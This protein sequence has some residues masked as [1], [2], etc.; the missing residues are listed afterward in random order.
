MS[1]TSSSPAK[2][3]NRWLL[4]GPLALAALLFIGYSVFWH[5]GA[6]VMRDEVNNW[7]EGERE[8]GMTV[9]HDQIKVSGYPFFLRTVI[10]KP[11]YGN[12]QDD[13]TWQG[14]KLLV[15]V[16]PFNPTRLILSPFGKQNIEF[17][18]GSG[19]VLW[20]V[21]AERMN[22]SLAEDQYAIEIHELQASTAEATRAAP[23]SSIGGKKL[24]L[25]IYIADNP[26]ADIPG[27]LGSLGL[28]IQG[29]ALTTADADTPVSIDY[30][31]AALSAT[32]L[33]A[34]ENKRAGES[35]ID[36]WRRGNGVLDIEA[37]QLIL[38][39]GDLPAPTQI[40]ANGRLTVDREDYPAGKIDATIKD[41]QALLS[42]LQERGAI[43]PSDAEN[44]DKML[45]GMASSMGGQISAPITM[46]DGKA[47]I[48]F[49]EIADLE[50]LQ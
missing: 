42:I 14:E 44:A 33:N 49:I 27:D 45:S 12:P 29:L 8:R 1:D 38:S 24:L 7:I 25:N 46:E 39:N 26:E 4:Y 43:S 41:H 23:L 35:D 9:T 48:G 5:I 28:D 16:S 47:K 50:K 3:A 32:G 13:W 31:G 2:R 36:A 22:A 17:M 18:S 10:D 19:P 30:L 15:D 20:D 34:L 21:E 40:S 6:G 11:V 37:F